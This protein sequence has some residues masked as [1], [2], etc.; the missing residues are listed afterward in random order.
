M[1]IADYIILAILL[2]SLWDGYRTGFIRQLVRLFGTVVAYFAAWQFHGLLTPFLDHLLLTTVFKHAGTAVNHSIRQAIP[3]PLLGLL[4]VPTN[5]VLVPIPM[6]VKAIASALSFGIVFYLA[7]IVVRFLGGF[8]NSIFSLPILSFVNRLGGLAAGAVVAYL[9][10]AVALSVVPFLPT[11]P[12]RTQVQDSA[13]APMF[14]QP[15]TQ[16]EKWEGAWPSGNKR[17]GARGV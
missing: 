11:S 14:K 15:V 4:G 1:D 16:L 6:L 12:V 3:A 7:L 10:I 8:L 13:L 5:Q 2:F 9:L 17:A